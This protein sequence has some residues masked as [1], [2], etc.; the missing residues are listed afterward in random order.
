MSDVFGIGGVA[1]AAGSVAGAGIQAGATISAANT[2]ADAAKYAA[3]L[4]SQASANSLAFQQQTWNQ[5]QANQKPFLQAG[6]QS[7]G[8]LSGETQPGGALNQSWNQN[9]SYSP[10]SGGQPYSNAS[11]SS[12][13]QPFSFSGV[14]ESNDPAYQFD[15][16]QGEQAVQRSAAAQ[17]GLVSGGAMKDLND[18]AQGYASNQYQQSYQNALQGYQTNF[19]N[20]LAGYQTNEQNSLN[21]YQT[22]FGDSLAGYQTNYSNALQQYQTA[23]NVFENNQANSFNRQAAVAGIGQTAINNLS[24]TGAQTA[25]TYANTSLTGAAGAGNYLTQGASAIGAGTIGIG[26]AL[27]SGINGSVNA[28]AQ[29]YNQN[30]N[31]S[32]FAN[33]FDQSASLATWDGLN[34]TL[35]NTLSPNQ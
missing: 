8:N 6:Q 29:G 15:L 30:S 3:N 17:G 13:Q 31:F 14:N 4:Q 12:G 27:Q 21:Q 26:N 9:F 23:Y 32:N 18:Y 19:N 34:A 28:L 25:N 20:S 33:S 22:N 5:T 16:Q 24:A 11:F 10:F 2:E 1:Q 7:I 35:N